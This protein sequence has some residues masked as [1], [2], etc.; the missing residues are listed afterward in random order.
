MSAPDAAERA[1]VDLEH[2]GRERVGDDGRG[3]AEH[4]V[5]EVVVRAAAPR[6]HP[7]G[8]AAVLELH[9]IERPVARAPAQDLAPAA[10][11]DAAG[12]ACSRRSRPR[13]R[14]GYW[15]AM[16]HTS[17]PPQSWPAITTRSA[18]SA[19][20]SPISVRVD[21]LAVVGDVGLVGPAVAGQVGRDHVE[22]GRAERTELVPPRV[23]DLGE[24]VQQQHE[25]TVGRARLEAE[26]PDPVRRPRTGRACS[27]LR[28]TG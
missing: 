23:R 2:L 22:A 25:R 4:H 26:Q 17:S 18:P 20:T 13:S 21:P 6:E 19:S 14:S 5:D 10:R 24:A 8:H 1:L 9:E 11:A 3:A 12:R 27:K 16:I 7:L 15:R 28:I